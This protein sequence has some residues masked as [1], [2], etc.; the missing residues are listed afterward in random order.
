MTSDVA[1]VIN[2]DKRQD[3]WKYMQKV[4]SKLGHA[5]ERMSA[6]DG[7][8]VPLSSVSLD[9]LVRATLTTRKKFSVVHIESAGALGCMMSHRNAWMRVQ[10]LG[11]PTLILEDD[12]EP[13]EFAGTLVAKAKQEVQEGTWDLVLLGVHEPPAKKGAG[14]S[15]LLSW[16]ETGDR[17]T[18]SW[19]YVVSPHAAK[20]LLETSNVMTYQSDM[21]LHAAGL[22]VGFVQA[23]GQ[24]TFFQ[25]PDIRHTPLEP[26]SKRGF[27]YAFVIGFLVAAV[28]AYFA[29][30]Q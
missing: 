5:L 12:A 9:P 1:L 30:R 3:R 23:F 20:Q 2:L 13:N 6:V 14:I 18:G 16:M 10:E 25:T 19:A 15:R 21:H 27:V 26:V 7:H 17:Y 24:A 22:R 29:T 11:V 8:A 4:G 28:L